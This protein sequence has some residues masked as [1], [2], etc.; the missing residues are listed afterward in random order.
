M[1]DNPTC[2][3]CRW[4]ALDP[5]FNNGLGCCRRYAPRPMFA[6]SESV[7]AM[8]TSWPYTDTEKWC[9]EH[10]PRVVVGVDFGA[11]DDRTVIVVP[12]AEELVSVMLDHGADVTGTPAPGDSF[13]VGRVTWLYRP[14]ESPDAFV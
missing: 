1:A 14:K 2:A 12:T 9:G 5:A 10:A 6:K 4:F 7:Q 13:I 3:T 11:G 8:V